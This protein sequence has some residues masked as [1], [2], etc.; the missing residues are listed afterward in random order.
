MVLTDRLADSPR[1]CMDHQPESTDLIA[2]ELDEVIPAPRGCELN[3]TDPRLLFWL[4]SEVPTTQSAEI[5][6]TIH[7]V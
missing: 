3:P 2:L 4:F 1:A 6:A 7:P 5:M